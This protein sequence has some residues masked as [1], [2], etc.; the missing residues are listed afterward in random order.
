MPTKGDDDTGA[1]TDAVGN[2][3]NPPGRGMAASTLPPLSTV[4]C[5]P[6][7]NHTVSGTAAG[8]TARD[9]TF[10]E[11]YA[12]PFH[13]CKTEL[14]GYDDTRPSYYTFVDYLRTLSNVDAAHS[15]F[16]AF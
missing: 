14:F 4:D 8:A 3:E 5:G 11:L 10:A 16:A 15:N 2:S 12:L 9:A 7:G 13:G 6:P 1:K